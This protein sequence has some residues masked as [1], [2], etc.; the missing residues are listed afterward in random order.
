MML[1]AT[2]IVCALNRWM[3][4]VHDWMPVIL[5]QGD[6]D[7]W[8]NETRSDPLVPARDDVLQR[9]LASSWMNLACYQLPEAVDSSDRTEII[10]EPRLLA[11]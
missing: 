6:V 11:T 9:C 7:I 1:S 10:S 3:S 2:I 4:D 8:L 5:R